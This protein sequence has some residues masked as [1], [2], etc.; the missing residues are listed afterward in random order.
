MK[1][2]AFVFR[3][4]P[5]MKAQ[6]KKDH[7]EI[8]PDMAK[9]IHESGMNNYSIFFRGDGTLFAYL[10][11]EDPEKSFAYIGEQEVNE[12]WQ[13]AMD[14]YFIKEDSSLLGPEMEELE[15]V[16]HLD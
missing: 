13:K 2:Y 7:D 11:A 14:R 16:F 6:Y 15:E 12:R 1:R 3:I 4:K 5:E 9:A 10:E 8:W